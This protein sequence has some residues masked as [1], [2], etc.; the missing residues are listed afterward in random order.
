MGN[1][2]SI[3]YEYKANTVNIKKNTRN[4]ENVMQN[5]INFPQ[6]GKFTIGKNLLYMGIKRN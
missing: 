6:D 3:I 1:F 5:L 4:I 2:S